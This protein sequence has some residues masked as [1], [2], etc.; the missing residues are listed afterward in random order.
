MANIDSIFLFIFI[1]SILVTMKNFTKFVSAL[2]SKELKAQ[3]FNN[4]ELII[5]G[6]SISYI[7]TYIISK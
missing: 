6:M 7:L 2:L 3:I 1:F 5:F 4:R